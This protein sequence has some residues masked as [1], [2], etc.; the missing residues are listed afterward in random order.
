MT[1]SIYI[2]STKWDSP[3]IEVPR[4]QI[5]TQ[6]VMLIKARKIWLK[7]WLKAS[8]AYKRTSVEIIINHSMLFLI[9][10]QMLFLLSI[11]R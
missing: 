5:V 6:V 2:S 1:S 8:Y 10:L 7:I 11:L 4:D 3:A 9:N